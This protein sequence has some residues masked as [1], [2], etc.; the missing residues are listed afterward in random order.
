MSTSSVRDTLSGS[1]H[2]RD[3]AFARAEFIHN[4]VFTVGLIFLV[5]SPFWAIIDSLMLPEATQ[6]AAIWGRIAMVAGLAF[7][8]FMARRSPGRIPMARACAGLLI[9]LPAAFFALVLATLP[10][11]QANDLIGYSFIPY[12]LIVVLGIFPFTLIESAV[13][14]LALIALQVFALHV[15]GQWLSMKGI[16]EI[17]LLSALLSITLT[18]NHFHLGMLLRLYREATHDPL[19]GLLNRGAL[20][21]S[22]SQARRLKDSQPMALLMMDL[23]H[24]KRINDERGHSVGDKVLRQFTQLLTQSIKSSDI[25]ARYGGEEFMAVLLNTSKE[26]AMTI[27]EQLRQRVE[28][29]PVADH[30]GKL[31]KI[32]V[33]IG[34]ATLYPDEPLE[35]AA[36]RADDRLYEAKKISR[37]CVV[38]V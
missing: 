13:F 9:G 15:S 11:G 30:E 3:F 20:I 38:G 35:T 19:T 28:S 8:V 7:A 4:R 27:A 2:S 33:S 24:F 18:T 25:A 10:A 5:L 31:F 17:W 29:S 23:D 1:R 6:H 26:A 36:R 12:M 16:Q 34:V 32:T 14:G 22:V 37:N 21:Q